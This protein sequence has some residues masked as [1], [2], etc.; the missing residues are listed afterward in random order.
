MAMHRI[1]FVD[2]EQ[3]ILNVLRRLFQSGEYEIHTANSG[4]EALKIMQEH[5]FSLIVSDY[6]MPEMNGIEFLKLAK[7]K[8]PNT[9]RIVLTGYA[10]VDVA[11]AAINEGE[12]Y[13]FVEK[14][15]DEENLR[16]QIR[17]AI[18]HYELVQEREGLV[19]R[20]HRQNE[21]LTEYTNELERMVEEKTAELQKAYFVL[22]RKVK[23]LEARD[24]ILE[25][26]L[27]VHSLD[28][29][30]DYMLEVIIAVN[31]FDRMVIYTADT[32]ERVLRPKAG[33]ELVSGKKRKIDIQSSRLPEIPIPAYEAVSG[34]A[35]K[36]HHWTKITDYSFYMP[37][38]KDN[39]YIGVMFVDK[40]TSRTPPDESDIR[41][42]GGFSALAAIA[43]NDHL[44]TSQLPNLQGKLNELLRDL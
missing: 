26:L 14:P 22:Q 15:W 8:S 42:V 19:K 38:I 33:V 36:E 7:E 25:H 1:L 16:V 44:V 12:A 28:E 21:M 29:T 40:S 10:D 32:E 34:G 30:L 43:V 6:R 2:D 27:S 4:R 18:E 20:I 41:F 13:K 3:N 9:I 31:P 24:T 35:A 23:E 5:V 37:I 39:A 17:R 11:M